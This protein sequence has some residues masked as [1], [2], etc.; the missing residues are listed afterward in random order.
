MGDL[1]YDL[2]TSDLDVKGLEIGYKA[3]L[4]KK[5]K[6]T[7]VSMISFGII[8]I[9]I[10]IIRFIVASAETSI[11]FFDWWMAGGISVWLLF[12]FGITLIIFPFF[13]VRSSAKTAYKQH[14]KSNLSTSSQLKIFEEGVESINAQISASLKW[15]Q[16]NYGC[17]YK[18]RIVLF[19]GNIMV[20]IDPQEVTEG[21]PEELITF[22][23]SKIT[24][25]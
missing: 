23:K 15:D 21:T 16:I 20:C 11:S 1:V 6:A 7:V 8:F 9:I 2:S 4:F 19:S 5:N 13:V 18:D 14:L 25:K 3:Y 17:M 10:N 24:L 12:I 22:I